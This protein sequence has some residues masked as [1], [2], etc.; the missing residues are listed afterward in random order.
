MLS[1]PVACRHFLKPDTVL[2]KIARRRATTTYLV[3]RCYPML[4]HILSEQLCRFQSLDR[5]VIFTYFA[6]T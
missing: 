5:G 4:P 3:Q 1:H 6:S 2:D